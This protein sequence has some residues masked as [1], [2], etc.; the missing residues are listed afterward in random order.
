MQQLAWKIA[1]PQVTAHVALAI[2]LPDHEHPS[3]V[4]RCRG[5][6]TLSDGIVLGRWL[7][8]KRAAQF[9]I[10]VD[11]WTY[12]GEDKPAPIKAYQYLQSCV[13]KA[14]VAGRNFG[15]FTEESVSAY[16]LSPL[17]MPPKAARPSLVLITRAAIRV[18]PEPAVF[19][20]PLEAP[21]QLLGTGSLP[22]SEVVSTLEPTPFLG[23]IF[24]PGSFVRV[25]P[26]TTPGVRPRH[27][28]GIL[29]AASST[30]LPPFIVKRDDLLS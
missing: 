10:A 21:L 30:P 28:E 20:T 5:R 13:D 1:N 22:S 18:Y 4:P 25:L 27:A 9:V 8:L 24:S 26:D 23:P 7:G 17:L 15:R 19:L 6:L 29:A 16:L 14:A 11:P 12:V 2:T 3:I